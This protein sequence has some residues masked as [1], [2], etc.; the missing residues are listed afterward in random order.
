M[1][2]QKHI[3]VAEDEKNT[4]DTLGFLL[5]SANY[6]VDLVENGREALITIL[7]QRETDQPVDLLVTDW[8]M[9]VMNGEELLSILHQLSIKIPVLIIT[10]YD[11]SDMK[12]WDTQSGNT[13][14]LNK[15]FSDQDFLTRINNLF[16]KKVQLSH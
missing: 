15:P 4:L 10:S 13:E 9:P 6:N 3:L 14:Y 12:N 7:T 8:R 11:I 16:E 1:N 5:E 2:Q